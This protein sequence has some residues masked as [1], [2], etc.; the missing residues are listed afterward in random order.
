MVIYWIYT[1]SII[2]V[3]QS[4]IKSIL[5]IYRLYDFLERYRIKL[6][7]I[8]AYG[9]ILDIYSQYYRYISVII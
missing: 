1:I 7:I 6:S 3:L 8:E 9:H 5:S 4:S 2:D